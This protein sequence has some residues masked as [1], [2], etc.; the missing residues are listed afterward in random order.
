MNEPEMSRTARA[1]GDTAQTGGLAEGSS[2][3]TGGDLLVSGGRGL[4]D[5]LPRRL[6]T[7]GRGGVA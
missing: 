6:V 3:G 2:A 4:A 5:L 1:G 7:A